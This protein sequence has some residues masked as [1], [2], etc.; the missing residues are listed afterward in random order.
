[1]RE[2]SG[3]PADTLKRA[4]FSEADVAYILEATGQYRERWAQQVPP[5]FNETVRGEVI[6]IAT[7]SFQTGMVVA[8]AKARRIAGAAKRFGFIT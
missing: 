4:G 2:I 3:V 1:M 6:Q 8:F 7:N 5:T